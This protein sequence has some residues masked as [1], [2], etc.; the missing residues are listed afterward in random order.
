VPAGE[1]ATNDVNAANA[2]SM[3]TF[4]LM[5]SIN[6]AGKVVFKV[7][8]QYLMER[9]DRALKGSSAGT[10]RMEVLLSSSLKLSM[11]GMACLI[12]EI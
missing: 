9:L 12:G 8:V 4:K 1:Y 6:I 10:R 11:T 5:Q 3:P 2:T 7:C